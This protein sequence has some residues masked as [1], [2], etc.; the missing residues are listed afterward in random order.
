MATAEM[1]LNVANT[2]VDTA[3]TLAAGTV[4]QVKGLG[5]ATSNAATDIAGKGQNSVKDCC[6]CRG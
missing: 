6:R 3:K 2:A 4:E 1:T 5:Q